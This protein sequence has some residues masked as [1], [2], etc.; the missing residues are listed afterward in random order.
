MLIAFGVIFELPVVV[1]ILSAM[2]LITP[3]FLREKRRHAIVAF[4]ILASLISPADI[5]TTFLMM[6]PLILLYEFSI[7][8]SKMIHRGHLKREEEEKKEPTEEPPPGAVEA[9]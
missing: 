6:G 3:D 8:L 4:T 2:G 9:R 1:M 7:L 5:V